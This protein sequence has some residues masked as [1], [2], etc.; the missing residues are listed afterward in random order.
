MML[1]E[2]FRLVT[3]Y[4]EDFSPPSAP[5]STGGLSEPERARGSGQ[6]GMKGGNKAEHLESL[7]KCLILTVLSSH[8]LLFISKVHLPKDVHVWTLGKDVFGNIQ[9][10]TNR[11]RSLKQTQCFHTEKWQ[12]TKK[13]DEL[14]LQLKA[15]RL[16]RKFLCQRGGT[17]V[18]SNWLIV[19]S[20]YLHK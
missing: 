1:L 3:G 15:D 10:C 9:T 4:L 14:Q 8:P 7:W 16:F 19:Q 13:L 2:S 11:R 12:T 6:S 17:E 5:R 20:F 18:N